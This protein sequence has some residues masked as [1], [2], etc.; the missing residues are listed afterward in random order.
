METLLVHNVDILSNIDLQLLYQQHLE[1]S[2]L[3]TL[4]VSERDTFH[5]FR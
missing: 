4:V 3:A 2:P 1:T 5:I